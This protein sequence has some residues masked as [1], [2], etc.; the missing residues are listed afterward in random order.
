[1]LHRP[2]R[3]VARVVL[4]D[5]SKLPF[6]AEGCVQILPAAAAAA[7]Q[8]SLRLQIKPLT[9]PVRLGGE[10]TFRITVTNTGTNSERQ[11]RVAITKP[12]SLTYL[13]SISPVRETNNDGPNIQF[14]PIKELRPGEP[15]TLDLRFKTNDA[16]RS[17]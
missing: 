11:V 7:R 10:A 2:A 6:A 1:M 4:T 15:I 13:G 12:D 5:L 8:P 16:D 14:E 9:N 17:R 3:L